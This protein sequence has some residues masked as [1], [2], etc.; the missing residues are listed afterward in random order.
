MWTYNR[1]S[2]ASM[3]IPNVEVDSKI[4]VNRPKVHQKLIAMSRANKPGAVSWF[5]ELFSYWPNCGIPLG[6]THVGEQG[7]FSDGKTPDGRSG[8]VWPQIDTHFFDVLKDPQ[9]ATLYPAYL[10]L[11]NRQRNEYQDKW[12]LLGD[13][14]NDFYLD[15]LRPMSESAFIL[16]Y[17]AKI[18]EIWEYELNA[19]PRF[20]WDDDSV[21]RYHIDFWDEYAESNRDYLRRIA[22]E[23]EAV[24]ISATTPFSS[25]ES[26][27]YYFLQ[28]QAER[29]PWNDNTCRIFFLGYDDLS[30]SEKTEYQALRRDI[31]RQYGETRKANLGNVL[32][33]EMFKLYRWERDHSKTKRDTEEKL[34]AL[35]L[36]IG[37]QNAAA[38]EARIKGNIA[39]IGNI[40]F[41]GTGI[42]IGTV[43]ETVASVAKVFTYIGAGALT[44]AT[45]GIAGAAI[46]GA[47][48]TS[49]AVGTGIA[50]AGIG[51]GADAVAGGDV[52]GGVVEKIK[53]ATGEVAGNF[54]EKNTPNLGVDTN[55]NLKGGSMD[56]GNI[57]GNDTIRALDSVSLGNIG[58]SLSGVV[59]QIGSATPSGI[60]GSIQGALSGVTVG[61]ISSIVT[62]TPTSSSSTSSS[63][64]SSPV[65]AVAA[66]VQKHKVPVAL[67][68]AV[69]IAA[70]V[71]FRKAK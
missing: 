24:L 28:T 35:Y 10:W 55:L 36:S 44:V 69:G 66:A 38:T 25:K 6:P 2:L 1:L 34:N 59:S 63:P 40:D 29:F 17:N 45:G 11:N 42:G 22:K 37:K 53:P 4:S 48:G 15:R 19:F 39:A 18:Q 7:T 8:Y 64:S 62:P 47:L 49:A 26:W 12:N 30:P 3:G 43:L 32:Y 46:G 70:F 68:A 50:A 58:S 60:L 56:F 57:F 33:D 61:Q 5:W 14:Y 31:N 13:F 52:L 51:A 41:A 16:Q 27:F 65:A 20:D 21:C 67:V 54:L 23:R 9:L 71:Y